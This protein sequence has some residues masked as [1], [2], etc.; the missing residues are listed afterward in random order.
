MKEDTRI[1]TKY[2]V[3]QLNNNLMIFLP[4]VDV[5]LL[6]QNLLLLGH[7]HAGE[8]LRWMLRRL[9][10]AH[11]GETRRGRRQRA[12]LDRGLTTKRRLTP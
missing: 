7:P 1:Q 10:E 3:N 4:I 11:A 12:V 2:K 6:P 8:T 5:R 9:S